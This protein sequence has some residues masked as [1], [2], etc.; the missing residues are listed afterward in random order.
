MNPEKSYGVSFLLMVVAFAAYTSTLCVSTVGEWAGY[1]DHLITRVA[2]LRSAYRTVHV[3][4][5]FPA[6][7]SPSDICWFASAEEPYVIIYASVH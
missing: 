4:M 2:D 3:C 6:V 7:L 1:A 5:S